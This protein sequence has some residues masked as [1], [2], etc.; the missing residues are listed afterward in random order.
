MYKRLLRPFRA[1]IL[2]CVC[3]PGRRFALPWA[4]LLK[5]FGLGS[6]AYLRA[7]GLCHPMTYDLSLFLHPMSFHH[8]VEPGAGDAQEL[9]GDGL[10][11]IGGG[12]C[13]YKEFLLG[14]QEG[15]DALGGVGAYGSPPPPGFGGNEGR[16]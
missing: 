14:L 16:N 10:I 6:K 2:I 13:F 12:E 5:P 15:R 3:N 9:C 7:I 11:A 4:R 8:L 1:W